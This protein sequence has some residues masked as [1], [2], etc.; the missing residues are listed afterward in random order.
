VFWLKWTD[1]FG[2]THYRSSSSHDRDIAENMLRD[3]LKRKADGLSASP[4]PRH[5]LVNDLLET[6][7]NRYRVEGRRSLERFEDAAQRGH[8][9]F[10]R[11]EAHRPQDRS[12]VPALRDGRRERLRD[13]GTKLTVVLGKTPEGP[14]SDN[15]GD[16][17][18]TARKTRRLSG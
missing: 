14:L 10:R 5:T 8:L 13:A 2:R 9:P 6:L 17:S 18:A 15:S 11:D 4:N 7:K 12:G 16:N 1:A 3:E